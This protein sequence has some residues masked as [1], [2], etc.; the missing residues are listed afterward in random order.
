M[1]NKPNTLGKQMTL[2]G[3]DDRIVPQTPSNQEGE[4]KPSNVGEGRRS[5]QHASQRG[6]LPYSEMDKGSTRDWLA[7]PIEQ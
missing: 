4:T 5:G 1:P 6:Q 3:S 2:W 7:S